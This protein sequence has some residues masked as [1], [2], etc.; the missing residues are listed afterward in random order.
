MT[1]VR[2]LAANMAYRLRIRAVNQVGPGE[3]SLPSLFFTT[4]ATA[5]TKMPLNVTGGGGKH[6]TLVFQW[7]P[8][9]RVDQNGPNFRYRGYI[10]AKGDNEYGAYELWTA[11][12][13]DGGRYLQYTHM[14]GD[15]LYYKPYEVRLEAV[16]SEAS[17]IITRVRFEN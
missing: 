13:I 1:F 5:P 7:V 9:S 16:N 8:L 2:N 12:P 11:K 6:G 15:N 4:L 14:L 10:R 17:S 3:P